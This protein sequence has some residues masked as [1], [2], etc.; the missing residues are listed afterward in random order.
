MILPEWDIV[1]VVAFDAIRESQ[2]PLYNLEEE[3]RLALQGSACNQEY[4]TLAI[5]LLTKG[6][7][8]PDIEDINTNL[9]EV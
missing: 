2:Q 1:D 9:R 6:A 7:R 4:A 5:W 8:N 3:V